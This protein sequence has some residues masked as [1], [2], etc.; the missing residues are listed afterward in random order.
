MNHEAPSF[1]GTKIGAYK[2]MYVHVSLFT[3]ALKYYAV[4]LS[5]LNGAA[6]SYK[7]ANYEIIGVP[8]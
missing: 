8:D 4:K 5:K 2:L 6:N 1:N 7:N 3:V